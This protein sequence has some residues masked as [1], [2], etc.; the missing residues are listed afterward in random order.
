MLMQTFPP[1]PMA[2]YGWTVDCETAPIEFPLQHQLGQPGIESLMVPRPISD[3]PHHVGSGRLTGKIAVIV[4]GDSGIGRAIAYLYAREGADV[5]IL[6][7]NE[8]GDAA[9]TRD[10]IHA[11][12]RNCLLIAGDAGDE[13]WCMQAVDIAYAAM[14]RI[15]ILVNNA[16]IQYVRPSISEI[17]SEELE[18]T[19]RTN[20]FSYFYMAKAVA[21]YMQPGSVIVN[22]TS[23]AAVEG[24][25][26]I[27]SYSAA[28]GAV[29]A[30]TRSL[31]ASLIQRGIRVNAVAP[32]RTWTPLVAAALPPAVYTTYGSTNLLK[33]AAQPVEIAPIY[34]F[35]ATSD[36]SFVIGQTIHVD[37]GEYFGL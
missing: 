2:Q 22:T 7:W 18:R 24:Y 14:G 25:P 20:L 13:A 35:L 12:G 11:I 31:A 15:D 26:H 32:G 36:S 8:H 6:Y 28:K 10:R 17:T 27:A 30:M 9:E 33:R 3:N 37:G 1:A 21:R 16:A 5:V 34:L 4:G 23:I 29:A 19:F